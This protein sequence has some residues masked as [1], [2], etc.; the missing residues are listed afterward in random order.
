M[1]NN[2][3]KPNNPRDRIIANERIRAT[4]VRV[5]QAEGESTVMSTTDAIQ[6]ANNA[7]LDLI[8]VNDNATPPLCKLMDMNKYLYEQKQKEK[9]TKKK[10][11]ESIV[12]Q[13][14]IRMGLNIDTNDLNTKANHAKKFIEQK[15][16]VTVTVVLKGRERGRQDMA[17]DLLGSFA[18]LIDAEYENISGQGNRVMGRIK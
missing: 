3:R 6:L 15:A 7:E 10:Q 8:L 13:K 14:E 12:E 4:E 5:L 9:E 1:R 11:R 17:R 2:Q 16:K 18:E